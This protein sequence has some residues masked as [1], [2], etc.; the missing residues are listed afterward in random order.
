MNL[1]TNAKEKK[2][3]SLILV[4]DFF[5]DTALILQ[6]FVWLLKYILNPISLL[7]KS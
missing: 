4:L 1:K 7:T 6:N 3:K 5:L 2:L